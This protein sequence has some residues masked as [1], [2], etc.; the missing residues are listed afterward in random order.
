ME[1]EDKA[2][3]FMIGFLIMILITC[4]VLSAFDAVG[5]G[6]SIKTKTCG[7]CHK[8]WEVGTEN[9]SNISR[10]GMCKS[11]YADYKFVKDAMDALDE[12]PLN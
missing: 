6:N 12:L 4:L 9:A 5:D 3:L 1:F 10:T 8:R 7:Y 2:R 11:C